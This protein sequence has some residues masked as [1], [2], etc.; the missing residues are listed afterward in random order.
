MP[1]IT[2][3]DLLKSESHTLMHCDGIPSPVSHTSISES[4]L[5]GG[6][7]IV[8]E[9]SIAERAPSTMVHVHNRLL[10]FETVDNTPLCLKPPTKDC[11]KHP[12]DNGE[13]YVAYACNE[14]T[15]S[16]SKAPRRNVE[17]HSWINWDQAA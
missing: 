17:W 4:E 3:P 9:Y 6:G 8:P 1:S 10:A 14:S 16:Y 15:T 7:R 5:M 2:I 13:E 11:R 12:R